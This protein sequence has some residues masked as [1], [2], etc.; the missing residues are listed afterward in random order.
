MCSDFDI[1]ISISSVG[2]LILWKESGSEKVPVRHGDNPSG[3]EEIS[4]FLEYFFSFRFRVEM[5]KGCDEDNHIKCLSEGID[6]LHVE[7]L[8]LPIS[9]EPLSFCNHTG[10]FIDTEIIS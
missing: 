2:L 1:K 9:M 4:S 6:I 8:K 5:M 7:Y 10:R 3:I